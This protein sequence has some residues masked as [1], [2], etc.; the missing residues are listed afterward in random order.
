VSALSGTDPCAQA[1]APRRDPVWAT[2]PWLPE[3]RFE[4]ICAAETW[5]VALFLVLFLHVGASPYLA[6]ALAGSFFCHAYLERNLPEIFT[7]ILVGLSFAAASVLFLPP[8]RHYVGFGLGFTGACFGCGSLGVLAVKLQA[9]TPQTRS[10]IK[11]T[12]VTA[13]LVPVLCSLSLW[14][15]SQVSNLTTQ[16]FDFEL[17]RFDRALGIDTFNLAR[18]WRAHRDVYDA[19]AFVYNALPLYVSACLAL[20]FRRNSPCGFRGAVIGLGA[21]GFA[22]YQ[23]CPA[24]GPLYRFPCFPDCLPSLAALPPAVAPLRAPAMNAMP[25]LH[26]AWTLLCLYYLWPRGF[27]MR[28]LAG[29]VVALTAFATLVSGE[30]YVV[31]LV[32]ALPLSVALRLAF[33]PDLRHRMVISALSFAVV[34]TWVVPGRFGLLGSA[35]S[36]A[37]LV[38]LAATIVLSALGILVAARASSN[39]APEVGR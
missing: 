25:S 8:F 34:L 13:A 35:P 33:C 12:L 22:L 11:N 21:I 16:T 30:H 29:S 9:A 1:L 20:L 4:R 24:A 23:I 14:A 3:S 36:P 38:S 31:D 32:V 2:R 18:V 5:L 6:F 7:A 28:L 39:P 10:R 37:A 15:V 26:V 17:Y 27:L 19:S